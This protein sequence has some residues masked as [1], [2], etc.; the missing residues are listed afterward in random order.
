MKT[1]SIAMGLA[2]VLAISASSQAAT[3]TTSGSAPTT[4][5]LVSQPVDTSFT[6]IG[7]SHGSRGNTF[8]NTDIVDWSITAITVQVDNGAGAAGVPAVGSTLSI[9]FLDNAFATISSETATTPTLADSV[10]LTITLATPVT[11]AAGDSIGF[12]LNMTDASRL[13]LAQA[14]DVYSG[15]GLIVN[16]A[17]HSALDMT[18][19]VQG[20]PVAVPEPTALFL[21][22]SALLGLSL[23]CAGRRRKRSGSVR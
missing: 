6:R 1:T 23:T 21:A 5:L 14:G 22:V 11:V 18:F 7:T 12:D 15:G 17:A 10:F 4:D 20:Q 9:D 3:I 19:F 2:A 16:G 13:Q 8:T